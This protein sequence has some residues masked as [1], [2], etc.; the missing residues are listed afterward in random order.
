MVYTFDYGHVWES[1]VFCVSFCDFVVMHIILICYIGNTIIQC[2]NYFWS[3]KDTMVT[4]D[5]GNLVCF[6]TAI[7]VVFVSL[8]YDVHFKGARWP[9]YALGQDTAHIER[10]L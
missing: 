10:K 3:L 9:L 2:D 8:Y 4:A 7:N 5:G 1:V 6:E